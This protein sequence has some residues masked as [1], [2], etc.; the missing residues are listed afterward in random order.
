[1]LSVVV[2]I[3]LELLPEPICGSLYAATTESIRHYL[4]N[5]DAASHRVD[6]LIQGD[7]LRDQWNSDDPFNLPTDH[8][9]T[10]RKELQAGLARLDSFEKSLTSE[11]V[12]DW[13]TPHPMIDVLLRDC[14]VIDTSRTTTLDS[15]S[16]GC[17]EILTTRFRG[18]DHQS[19]GGRVPNEN[20]MRQTLTWYI[21]G[22]S[23][24]VPLRGSGVDAPERPARADFPFMPE[25]YLA[26]PSADEVR[27]VA[28]QQ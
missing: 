14:L 4:E 19:C 23:R 13:P 20:V 17:L 3:P 21:N 26:H 1:M 9:A 6:R 15:S 7:D 8:E 10:Y 27:N 22:P 25:P 2:E 16:P 18:E 28:H 12:I 11:D 24:P 5:G